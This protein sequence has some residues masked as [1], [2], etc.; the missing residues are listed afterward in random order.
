M[1]GKN[2]E[3]FILGNFII[4]VLDTEQYERKL[5]KIYHVKDDT[6]RGCN[7]KPQN[8]VICGTDMFQPNKYEIRTET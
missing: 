3:I 7:L 1:V 8:Y 2:K 6:S 4:A 5:L